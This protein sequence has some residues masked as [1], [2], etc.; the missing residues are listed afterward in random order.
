MVQ[1]TKT[2]DNYATDGGEE[3]FTHGGFSA[4]FRVGVCRP[5]FQNGTI[6]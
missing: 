3:L 4:K 1:G 5:Q 6:G 2:I